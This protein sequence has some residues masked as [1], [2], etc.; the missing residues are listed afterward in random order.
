MFKEFFFFELKSWLKSP[1]VYLF[2][3][4]NFAM[5]LGA[6]LSENIMVGKDMGNVNINSPFALM[7]YAAI[8]SLISIVMTTTFVNQ[9]ALKDFTSNFH[10]ILFATPIKKTSYLLGRFTSSVLVSCVPLLG[11][12]LAVF[13]ASF[14][15]EDASMVGPNFIG[16]YVDSFFTFLLPNTILI[17]TIIFAVA[18]K[19]KSTTISFIGAIFLLLGYLMASSFLG[20]IHLGEAALLMD[21]FGVSSIS[22]ITKYWTLSEKNNQWL[23]LNGPMLLNR[24]IWFSVAV[25]I[26]LW[27]YYG[28]SFSLKSSKKSKSKE[29]KSPNIGSQFKVLDK[30]PLATQLHDAKAQMAQLWAQFRS[31]FYGVI[32]SPS[33]IV[34]LLFSFV[35]LMGGII[36][37]DS[38]HGSG[39][40]P[41][42]YYIL[43]GVTGSLHLFIYVIIAYYTGSLVWRERQA[44]FNEIVDASPFPAWVPMVSKYLS[45]F[46]IVFLILLLAMVFGMGVQAMKGYFNF[47]PLLYMKQLFLIDLSYFAILIAV[48]LFIHVLVN[49]MYVGIFLFTLFLV[50]N[51]FLWSGLEIES[52]L[53]KVAGTPSFTYSDFH[54]FSLGAAGLKWY[55][56]YWLLFAGVV[57]ILSI[58]FSVRGKA[59]KIRDRLSIAKDRF[60]TQM[61]YSFFGFFSL[62]L[63]VGGYLYYNANILNHHVTGA[64]ETARSISYEQKY[65]KYESIAQPRII[66]LDHEIEL[67]PNLRKMKNKTTM[68]LKN[69]HDHA[70]DSV[71]FSTAHLFETK[72]D[73][74]ASQLVYGDEVCNYFIYT[75]DK[76]LL[77][78]DSLQLVVYTAYEAKGIE[79]EVS[80]KWINENGSFVHANSFM[81]VIGY[82]AS[83]ENEEPSTRRKFGLEPLERTSKLDHKCSASCS[84]SYISSDSDW[85][86]LSATIST[87]SDQ[88]AIAP[89]SLVKEWTEGG[90]N[91]YRYELDQ[92]VLNFYSF[93]SARYEVQREQWNGVDLE[94]YYHKGHE[95]NVDKM[96]RSM[97]ESLTYFSENFSPYPHKEARII[98]FPRFA[99]FAQAFPGTM[100]YS[101]SMG[102][103]ANLKDEDDM[104]VVFQTV[105]HEMAH[106]WWA[107]QVIGSNMQ[108]ATMLS[109]TFAQYSSMMVLEKEYGKKQSQKFL[110]YQLENYLSYRGGESI[111]ELPL[112]KVENQDY[113][114]YNKGTVVMNAVREYLG[115]DSL[116]L[117]MQRFIERTAYQEPPYT[118][119]NVFM[120]ELEKM[121]PDTF[122]S[123]IDNMFKDIILYD[124]KVN[125]GEYRKL[126][127]GNYELSLDISVG[128]LKAD[129]KGKEENLEIDDYIYVGVYGPDYDEH[130]MNETLYYELHKFDSNN[131]TM[132]IILEE[133]P[134]TAGI[135]PGSL[136]IDR[137]RDD[138]VVELVTLD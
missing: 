69:K 128:K 38:R 100:P 114:H 49:N 35:N 39:N 135:D 21:P 3:F 31:D 84:N 109:E 62:W 51:S 119:S 13:V 22:E 20:N 60:N 50:A 77:P 42:T 78:G 54:Q 55:N 19:F 136:L 14:L 8:I 63:L 113:I 96:M 37:A 76:K 111:A 85:I 129:K 52:N 47:E 61:S 81:P 1:M 101:E 130:G 2:L 36:G 5:V 132:I 12:L 45:M 46:S 102:F 120:E 25:V 91:Y 89:G 108:G 126:D 134:Q 56:F 127:N 107:H 133:E 53:L 79:N 82:D 43:Q 17:A 58:L 83:N 105:A 116:N 95:Y 57:F 6:C 121:V 16:A 23:S 137:V 71:H 9:S 99:S 123:L 41:V 117:A 67:F 27:S 26:F 7:S 138:N 11:V 92:P 40:F 33:F 66:A 4:L 98:E 44:K 118:N 86:N 125:S 110:K 65:K 115:E 18:V 32:K 94:V 72:I 131:K 24:L 90:R 97:R 59:L 68:I 122:Q 106:Q 48:S 75:L 87:C 30:L 124:N 74:P 112:M 103:I 73:L 29:V 93:L 64:E 15:C 10:S 28:F 80:M 34:I 104:D 88:L 70:I